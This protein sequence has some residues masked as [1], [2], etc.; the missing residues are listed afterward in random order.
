MLEGLKLMIVGMAS[1]MIF[2]LLLITCIELIKFLTRNFSMNQEQSLLLSRKSGSNKYKD[3][4]N[5]EVPVEVFAA[6]I[7]YYELDNNNT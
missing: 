2:L 4:P 6:A 7:T 1:V 5:L 3:V